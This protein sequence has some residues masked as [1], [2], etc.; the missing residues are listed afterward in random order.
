MQGITSFVCGVAF[1]IAWML[2]MGH[3]IHVL[4]TIIGLV[5]AIFV[6]AWVYKRKF[7]KAK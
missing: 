4:E 7:W 2:L 6:G 5:I 1:F 3:Q